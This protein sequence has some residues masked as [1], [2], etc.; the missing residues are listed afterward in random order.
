MDEKLSLIEKI[1][2]VTKT[3]FYLQNR[4]KRFNEEHP[5]DKIS[6]VDVKADTRLALGLKQTGLSDFITE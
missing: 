5:D 2:E 6:Y 4:I 3:E 1:Q